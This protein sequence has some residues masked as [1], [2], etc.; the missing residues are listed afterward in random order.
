MKLI[1]CSLGIVIGS[2]LVLSACNKS[3]ASYVET[4]NRHYAAGETADAATA[5]R[6]AIQRDARFAEAH[7]RL[8][9][10][11]L[12]LQRRVEAV[13]AFQS[14]TQ[15]DPKHEAARSQLASVY[16]AVYREG[17]QQSHRLRE[18]VGT[19]AEALLALNKN[20]VQGL[21]VKAQIALLD[22]KT[23][24]ALRMFEQA[25]R[26]DPANPDVRHGLFEALT[27]SGKQAEAEAL[28]LR[29]IADAKTYGPMYTALYKQY[30]MAGRRDEAEK[31]LEKRTANDPDNAEPILDL[32]SHHLRLGKRDQ[33]SAILNRILTRPATFPQP[34][35][36]VGDFYSRL[37]IHEDAIGVF[38][39]GVAADPKSGALYRKRLVNEFLALGDLPRAAT[40]TEEAL[41]A[42]PTDQDLLAVRAFILLDRGAK[43]DL[44]AA[45]TAL[46]AAAKAKPDDPVVHYYLGRARARKGDIRAAQQEFQR[47]VSL[48]P[49]Y[50]DPTLAL[51]EIARDQGRYPEALQQGEDILRRVPAHRQAR[52]L[53]AAVLRSLNRHA[54]SRTILTQLLAEKP[55]DAQADM[56]LASADLLSG[57][58][59]AAERTFLKHHQLRPSDVRP[60]AGLTET[61]AAQRQPQKAIALLEQVHAR[62]PQDR[63]VHLLLADMY[64]RGG[65][66]DRA[67][68]EYQAIAAAPPPSPLA[69]LRL[70]QLH[71]K[72]GSIDNALSAFEAAAALMPGNAEPLMMAGDSASIAGKNA[73]A[74]AYYERVLKITPRHPIALNNVASMLADENQNLDQALTMARQAL[75]SA[76]GHVRLLDTLGWIYVR[77]NMTEQAL[78]VY[79]S[80]DTKKQ[81]NANIHY[82]HG[83]ALLKA[84]RKNDA[85]ATL[86]RALALKPGP[87]LT[88]R[89]KV[90]LAEV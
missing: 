82:H 10:A 2:L 63:P 41:K 78:Q 44:D 52:M 50:V 7:Y 48:R 4:G 14:A 77:K 75:E 29:T 46:E 13:A 85:R 55:D 57:N 34:H 40:A 70:G 18:R 39:A 3:A 21:R 67:L 59:A 53:K 24:E 38:Q 47:A 68:R 15:L 81:S 54:E 65:D 58:F 20:S 26:I 37:D 69:H 5:Y 84:G 36:I 27:Q 45:V 12:R 30:W 42:D 62:S 17:G 83:I 35:I 87:D 89:I 72:R 28:G 73:Q 23:A 74:K 56:E 31:L 88:S 49:N 33:A 19:A 51:A 79:S 60:L 66:L 64:G 76:P 80:I 71:F 9:L 86:E 22:G 1:R 8:G 43:E 25:H 61:Y 90:A 16:L 32:A 11:E 6:K